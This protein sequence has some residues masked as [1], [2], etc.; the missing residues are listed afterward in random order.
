MG[1]ENFS[2]DQICRLT[3]VTEEKLSN[4]YAK[5]CLKK[6]FLLVVIM[7]KLAKEK[8]KLRRRAE[9]GRPAHQNATLASTRRKL[10]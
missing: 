10:F 6:N 8:E 3:N 2:F 1:D 9:L 7:K 5:N 4:T